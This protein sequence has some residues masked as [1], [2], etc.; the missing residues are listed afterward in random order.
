[1]L[2]API[3]SLPFIYVVVPLS[4]LVNALCLCLLIRA[5]FGSLPE[6]AHSEYLFLL[7]SNTCLLPFTLKGL[8]LLGYQTKAETFF[9]NWM[10]RTLISGY[11]Y[12]CVMVS[13]VT[14]VEQLSDLFVLNCLTSYGQGYNHIP[15][16]E[17]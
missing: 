4:F 13:D 14:V 8:L 9:L 16:R 10:E 6:S 11:C 15:W 3:E 17:I 12:F 1:M 2:S 5:P 7:I